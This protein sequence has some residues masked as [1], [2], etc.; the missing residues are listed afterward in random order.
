MPSIQQIK[1]FAISEEDKNKFLQHKDALTQMVK[2]A[3]ELKVNTDKDNDLAISMSGKAQKFI[4]LFKAYVAEILE[5]HKTFVK[6]VNNFASEY[7]VPAD[8]IVSVTKKKSL[9][10]ARLKI[11]AE[12]EAAEKEKARLSS[13]QTLIDATAQ[14]A[15]VESITIPQSEAPE[16]GGMVRSSSGSSM[17]VKL[18]WK[19]IIINPSEVPREYC[20][21][22]QKLIDAAVDGGMREILGVR[23]E[24]VPEGRLR[25]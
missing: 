6:V 3:N 8:T 13:L 23:I 17:S 4:K 10:Y 19:G 25:V 18:K 16:I 14:E 12:R 1:E 24:E 5:P 7:M 15:G 22:D 20:S 21:P 11:I 9:E 2:Q